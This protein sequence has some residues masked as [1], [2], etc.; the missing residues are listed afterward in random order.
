M[1]GVPVCDDDTLCF[2]LIRRRTRLL[3]RLQHGSITTRLH[4][5]LQSHHDL[6]LRI[7]CAFHHR[8]LVLIRQ[9]LCRLMCDLTVRS[10]PCQLLRSYQFSRCPVLHIALPSS[11]PR[12]Q[13]HPAT[14][15]SR[16]MA[17]AH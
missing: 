14:G 6:R 4:H 10:A 13:S 11:F 12:A 15:R 5:L 7:A 17:L 16:Q 2:C 8:I 1:T 9:L 3:Q